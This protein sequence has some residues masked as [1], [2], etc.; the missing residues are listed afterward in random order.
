MIFQNILISQNFP[1]NFCI[2]LNDARIWNHI[3]NS[4]HMIVHTMF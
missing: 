1:E 2:L 4:I 3:D